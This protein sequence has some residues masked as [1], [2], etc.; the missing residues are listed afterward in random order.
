MSGKQLSGSHSNESSIS[1]APGV[2]N[3]DRDDSGHYSDKHAGDAGNTRSG[4]SAP[5]SDSTSGISDI[6]NIVVPP[7]PNTSSTA[8]VSML[9]SDEPSSMIQYNMSHSSTLP[10]LHENSELDLDRDNGE[11]KYFS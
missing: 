6:S 3:V 5:V 7:A 4:G 2:H 10:T 9:G 11:L 8:D 1:G